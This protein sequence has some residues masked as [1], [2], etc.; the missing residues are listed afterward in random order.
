MINKYNN[1]VAA[2]TEP[3][4]IVY[5]GSFLSYQS[6]DQ[7]IDV[8]GPVVKQKELDTAWLSRDGL[9]GVV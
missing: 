8:Q 6:N 2:S 3:G 4:H 7:N 1:V 5:L 9:R